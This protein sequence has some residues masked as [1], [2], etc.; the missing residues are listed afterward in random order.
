MK[1]LK[2]ILFILI[3]LAI[4]I[5][6][7]NCQENQRKSKAEPMTTEEHREVYYQYLAYMEGRD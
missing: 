4:V 2:R 6:I 5:I 1:I 3:A 7:I